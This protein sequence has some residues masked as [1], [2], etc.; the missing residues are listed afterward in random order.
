MKPGLIFKRIFVAAISAAVLV[1]VISCTDNFSETNIDKNAISVVGEA[2]L[3][4]LFSGALQ[5]VPWSNQTGQ[6]LAADQYAQYFACNATQF[7]SDRYTVNMSWIASNFNPYYTRVVPQLK[8]IMNQKDSQTAEHALANIWWV[9]AF[10]RVTDYW[11]PIPYFNAGQP[12]KSVPYDPQSEIYDDFFKKLDAAVKVLQG[13][14]GETPFGSFDF[15]YRGNISN[16]IKFAN[17]LRLRLAVRISKVDPARARTE[18]EAALQGGVLTSNSENGIMPRSDRHINSL[19]QMSEWNE[20]RMSA[21]M[22]SIMVGYD[23]PRIS[24]YFIPALTT[25]RY[26][27]LR[28]G[29]NV[30]QLADAMNRPNANSHVG[31]RWTAPQS[32]GIASY[33]STPFTIMTASEAC[34]LRAEGAVLGWNMGGTAK[35]LYETG[36]RLSMEQ[37]GVAD[38]AAVD[39]YIS[40]Q[41]KPIAPNDYMKSPPVS[42]V[43][44]K[45]DETNTQTQ[46]EQ[47]SIQKWLTVFPD[48]MEAWADN[49][50]SRAFKLYPVVNSDNPDIE[51]PTR[52]YIRRLP[53][54]LSERLANGVEMDRAVTLLNGPDK[55]NTPLW[56]DKN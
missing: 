16:W 37:W 32:G 18:A 35:E 50:R 3:P 23:D 20:F 10:H 2:E 19:S 13:K 12:A 38:Q 15:M 47:I 56:W 48:G 31:P 29:L 43:P 42:E 6:N 46:L 34:L 7:P 1:P 21:T 25:G 30:A 39:A 41:A 52:E 8:V 17:T 27:G 53:F 49:R 4:F 5:S 22:K 26:E 9:Y 51:D 45:F 33:L 36:I 11:G 40:S 14:T 44:V 24:E 55:I 54:L 28:N